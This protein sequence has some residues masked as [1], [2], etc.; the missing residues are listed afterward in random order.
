[1]G[2]APEELH[3]IGAGSAADIRDRRDLRQVQ[4]LSEINGV[5]ARAYQG[6]HRPDEEAGFLRVMLK[7]IRLAG[8]SAV[9]DRVFQSAPERE[10]LAVE[11][12][13]A[14]DVVAG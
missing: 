10:N 12:D 4:M 11:G 5:T 14:A 7:H 9:A 3:H 2:E 1:M 8:G 13:H 6:V